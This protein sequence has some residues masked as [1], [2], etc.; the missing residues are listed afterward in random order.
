MTSNPANGIEIVVASGVDD[1]LIAAFSRLIPQLSRTAAVPTPDVLRQ[2][3]EAEANTVL[4]ARTFA[5]V[6][7]SLARS[8]W[9]YSES[10]PAF[11]L[12]S[13]M[14]WWTKQ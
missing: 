3:V 5:M 2:I 1:E 13:R 8:R 14:S 11:E 4:I 7:G 9:W 10:R 12:G 6:R